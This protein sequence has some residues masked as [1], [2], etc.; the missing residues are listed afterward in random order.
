[1]T[2]SGSTVRR[3]SLDRPLAPVPA[4]MV[5]HA[6]PGLHRAVV[7]DQMV[8]LDRATGRGHVLNASAGLIFD[9][10]DGRRT[11]GQLV[12]VLA[13]ETGF[14]RA[15][16]AADVQTALADLRTAALVRLGPA[17]VDGTPPPPPGPT[18]N[19]TMT[20]GR[21][22]PV[23]MSRHLASRHPVTTVG[24]VALAGSTVAVQT[25]DPTVASR[26]HA[27]MGSLP[28]AATA[29]HTAAL[30]RGSSESRECWRLLID[31]EEVATLPSADVA[32]DQLLRRLNLDA[33]RWSTGN[34]LFHAGAV[35]HRGRAV[36]VAGGSGRGKSTLVA[37]LV[38]SGAGYLTDELVVVDPVNHEV[39]PFPKSLD[40]DARSRTL[41]GLP[42]G[43]SEA[44]EW[45]KR[46]V[47]PS[48]LGRVAGP[49]PF[50]LLV[51][52]DPPGG[53][54]DS[55]PGDVDPRPLSATE[56]LTGLL[57]NT[58]NE[59]WALPGAFES[60]A[61][62]CASVPAVRLPRVAPRTAASI[63]LEALR[64]GEP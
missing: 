50:G 23:P 55:Q 12:D 53:E 42:A 14:D 5:V 22:R 18:G 60:L 21:G 20:D 36:V 51:L 59:T 48:T 27:T 47:D 62:L 25:D 31:D 16:L 49:A 38:Q 45:D 33:A 52:L 24:P 56:A 35:V 63:V 39:R 40:L 32:I 6:T 57:P 46:P 17:P 28:S 29:A 3:F 11:V 7:D 37:A 61:A 34:L 64:A 2:T 54:G 10:V 30:L 9:A 43:E 15:R 19:K 41:L 26:L 8:I 44:Q 1:M 58:V 13:E 4:E